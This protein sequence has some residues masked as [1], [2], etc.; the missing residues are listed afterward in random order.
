VIPTLNSE[1]FLAETLQSVVQ[2]TTP[3]AEIILVDGGSDDSTIAIGKSFGV[4]IAGERSSGIAG[5]R[6]IGMREANEPW[7]AFLDHDDLW[8][9]RKLERQLA[10]AAAFPR[11]QMILTDYSVFSEK[12]DRGGSSD[13]SA[14]Y[15]RAIEQQG[16]SYFPS[17]DFTDRDW[18]V[19]LTSSALIKRG[20]RWF[21]EDLQGTDDIEF[22]LRMM[23]MPF[24]LLD[25]PL[26]RWR[27]SRSSYSQKDPVVLDLDFVVTM[28]KI[29]RSPRDYPR[30][31]FECVSRIRGERLRQTAW[32]LLRR[33]RIIESLSMLRMSRAGRETA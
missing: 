5:G 29:M 23:T 18:I 17:I 15:H 25:E 6:N 16:S 19:P 20:A 2:Q 32:K 31:I 11:A 21:D 9:P 10:A 12:S 22:F 13:A 8:E 30:G 26:T 1:R 33:G 27:L 7:V 14:V 24:I 3:P 28:D 4:K